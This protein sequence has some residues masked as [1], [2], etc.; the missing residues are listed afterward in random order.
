[1]TPFQKTSL[2][3]LLTFYWEEVECNLTNQSTGQF[4]CMPVRPTDFEALQDESQMTTCLWHS[5]NGQE[6]T[7]VSTVLPMETLNVRAKTCG[8]TS[9]QC[10]NIS[11][12]NCKL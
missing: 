3:V 2:H 7:K 1:M 8:N 4:D 12:N 11:L 9:F 6:I 10:R 5:M